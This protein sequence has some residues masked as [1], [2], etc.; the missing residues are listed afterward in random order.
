MENAESVSMPNRQVKSRHFEDEDSEVQSPIRMF[1]MENVADRVFHRKKKMVG[2][3][4]DD[5][6]RRNDYRNKLAILKG[7]L[8]SGSERMAITGEEMEDWF[9]NLQ[10]RTQQPK[11][12]KVKPAAPPKLAATNNVATAAVRLKGNVRIDKVENKITSPV[13]THQSH[14]RHSH[15]HRSA[16]EGI[17]AEEMCGNVDEKNHAKE[18]AVRS[19]KLERQS[20]EHKAQTRRKKSSHISVA[21]VASDIRNSKTRPHDFPTSARLSLSSDAQSSNSKAKSSKNTLSSIK[22]TIREEQ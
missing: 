8:E 16:A 4:D 1:S 5:E 6:T 2:E 22:S 11:D 17:I 9:Q 21:E 3:F 7:D 20:T 18:V 19:K 15:S 12:K 13:E 10:I 14:R